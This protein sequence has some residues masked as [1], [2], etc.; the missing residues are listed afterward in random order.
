MLGKDYIRKDYPALSATD[1]AGQALRLMDKWK[2]RQ[3]PLLEGDNYRRLVGE[4]E[5]RAMDITAP[6]GEEGR[7]AP[8]VRPSG[9]LHEI[10]AKMAHYGLSLLPVVTA[11]GKFTGVITREG[12]FDELAAWA[13]AEGGGS[14]LVLEMQ[15][16]D[17]ALS[18][19]ARILE[20]NNAHLLSLLSKT[21]ASGKLKLLLKID[22]D[23]AL[24]A[25]RSFE[26]FNYHVLYY[27]QREGELDDTL[28]QRLN[29]LVY[30]MRM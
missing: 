3:L 5:V 30:Y 18:D 21:D 27:F 19:I 15:T 10:V 6:L 29:E 16:R 25:V 2:V 11:K 1:K 9:H 7:F 8:S 26:R 22:L 17:Y 13:H 14:V 23:D 28:R 4:D 12:M 20:A 24:P